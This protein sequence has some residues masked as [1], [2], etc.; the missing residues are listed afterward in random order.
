MGKSPKT[1]WSM[2][3]WGRFSVS[4]SRSEDGTDTASLEDDTSLCGH[5]RDSDFA[6]ARRNPQK[7]YYTDTQQYAGSHEGT[8]S[9][10][11]I[12]LQKYVQC[13]KYKHAF[14]NC[15]YCNF[16]LILDKN[17]N[18]STFFELFQFWFWAI[19]YWGNFDFGPNLTV[20]N[21]HSR[22]NWYVQLFK[23]SRLRGLFIFEVLYSVHIKNSFRIWRWRK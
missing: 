4:I 23:N 1:G 15:Q 10:P 6:Q 21:F 18:S 13:F 16:G 14:W 12:C 8:T 9:F 17:F 20:Q 7:C 19:L 5:R 2:V 11:Y 22:K 3:S